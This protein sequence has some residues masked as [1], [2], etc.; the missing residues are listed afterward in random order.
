M[1]GNEIGGGSIRIHER[2]LQTTVFSV[3]GIDEDE[4]KEEF[5]HLL[6]AFSFGA[7]PHGGVALG[8]D[9]LVMLIAGEESIREVIAFPKNNRGIDLMS[10]SPAEVDFKQLRELY[11]KSTRQEENKP[12]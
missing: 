2:D 6:D 8:F 9:R 1:N 12:E 3:L 11:V 4:A 10:S 7:P 5:G